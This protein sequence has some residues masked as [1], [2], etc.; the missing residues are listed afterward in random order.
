MA[1]DRTVLKQLQASYVASNPSGTLSDPK[2][3]IAAQNYRYLTWRKDAEDTN[4]GDNTA[5][6]VIGG[7]PANSIVKR[8]YYTADANVAVQ[9][10]DTILLTAKVHTAADPANGLIVANG[11]M[12]AAGLGGATRWVPL[13]ITLVTANV[14]AAVNSVVTFLVTKANSGT[15]LAAGT[16][17]VVLEEV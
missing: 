12:T 9:T 11:I 14:T 16:V 10:N 2:A 8:V 5:E 17:T 1:T 13:D 4:A 3:A 6:F 7:V 15:K